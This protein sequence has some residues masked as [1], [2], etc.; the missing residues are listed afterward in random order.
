M[1]SKCLL[2]GPVRGVS[3]VSID[4]PRIWETSKVEPQFQFARQSKIKLTPLGKIPNEASVTEPVIMP[5]HCL[6]SCSRN[7]EDHS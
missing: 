4:T 1:L 5:N 7:L 3:G 6:V 2:R